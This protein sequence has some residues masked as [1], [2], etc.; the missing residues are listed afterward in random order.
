MSRDNSPLIKIKIKL[1]QDS[2]SIFHGVVEATPQSFPFLSDKN[3][4][5]LF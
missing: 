3:K 1:Y 4:I 2:G 5:I